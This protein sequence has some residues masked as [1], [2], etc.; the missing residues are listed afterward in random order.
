MQGMQGIK[1]VGKIGPEK[2][3]GVE[4][5]IFSFY[6]PQSRYLINVGVDV[7]TKEKP[8]IQMLEN[9]NIQ[10]LTK[11]SVVGVKVGIIPQP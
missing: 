1:F 3:F 9:I 7:G 10:D 4:K 6:I 8:S 5:T 11:Q 2:V